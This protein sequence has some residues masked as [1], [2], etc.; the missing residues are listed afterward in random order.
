MDNREFTRVIYR[1]YS[2][3]RDGNIHTGE[4]LLLACLLKTHG[5]G[6]GQ[7]KDM[8]DVRKIMRDINMKK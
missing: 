6:R 2:R 3:D 5:R 8:V 1:A 4:A 7:S